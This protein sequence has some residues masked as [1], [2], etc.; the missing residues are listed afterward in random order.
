MPTFN[1]QVSLIRKC[2]FNL[3]MASSISLLL[4]TRMPVHGGIALQALHAHLRPATVLTVAT[5]ARCVLKATIASSSPY[6]AQRRHH[7][8]SGSYPA[9]GGKLANTTLSRIA[10]WE[11]AKLMPEK[12][13]DKSM[14]R[15]FMSNTFVKAQLIPGAPFLAGRPDAQPA[16]QHAALQLWQPLCGQA[17]WSSPCSQQP[18]RWHHIDATTPVMP[19]S[20]RGRARRAWPSSAMEAGY[21]LI[22]RTLLLARL[23]GGAGSCRWSPVGD[24]A[25]RSRHLPPQFASGSL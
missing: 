3:E 22:V 23:H 19:L 6:I 11:K 1:L 20:P 13:T 18:P 14:R 4:P 21:V 9:P 24:A 12:T 8:S 15:T 16:L 10:V 2:A 25:T 7:S 17:A 5:S